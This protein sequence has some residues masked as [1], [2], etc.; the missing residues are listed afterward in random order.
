MRDDN[1]SRRTMLQLAGLGLTS[2]VACDSDLT[3]RPVS[4]E[5]ESPS[6]PRVSA[7][8]S[9]RKPAPACPPDWAKLR[10]RMEGELVLPGDASYDQVRLA[11]DPRF[12]G[13][14]PAAI[15][16]CETPSDVQAC[17]DAARACAIPIAARSGGH[18]YGGY[19]TPDAGLVID[20]APMS[21]VTV[22]ADGTAV[23]GAGA[24]LID[25]TTELARAGRCLPAGTCPSVGIAGLTLGGGIGVLA[26][27]HGLTCDRLLSADVV[28]ADSSAK[29]ASE[30]DDLLWALRGGG[31]GNFGIVTSFEFATAAAPPEITVFSLGFPPGSVADL[32]G[33]WQAWQPRMP[34]ELWSNCVVYGASPPGGSVGG[35][36]VG[37]PSALAPLLDELA[38]RVTPSSRTTT[39][40]SYLDAMKYYAGPG[41][42]SSFVASS[43]MLS[44][45]MTDPSRVASMLAEHPGVF[46]LFDALGGKVSDPSPTDT[47]FVH[48]GALAS[49]QATRGVVA[50]DVAGARADIT[51]V[52]KALSAIVGPGAYVNYID[53]EMSDWA[54]ACYG[55]NLARLRR[56]AEKCDPD[57][58]F[59]FAQNVSKA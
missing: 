22:R 53:P 24:T 38:A 44:A 57:G 18:S 40:M 1:L 28:L 6:T 21:A 9:V 41:G 5:A 2:L 27:L 20:L 4:V 16:K 33:A 48:R 25:V 13:R 36:F 34:R 45:P 37:S 43:R 39:S 58:V 26:R 56:V 23:V 35:A 55:D 15:A 31:G 49:V 32:L 19:S 8:P 10:E 59:A 51:Q 3:T 46:L 12:D 30:G 52:Q 29:H 50:G 54:S 47:A 11:F 7:R 14:L 17:L 42:R